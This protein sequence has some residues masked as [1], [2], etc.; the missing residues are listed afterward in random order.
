MILSSLVA[1]TSLLSLHCKMMGAEQRYACWFSRCFL[2]LM[3]ID[4]LLGGHQHH[5][6]NGAEMTSLETPEFSRTVFA[7]VCSQEM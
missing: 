1:A 4:F 5:G 2:T 6:K 3:F 7:D